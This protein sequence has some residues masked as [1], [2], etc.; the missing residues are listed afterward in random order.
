MFNIKYVSS[1]QVGRLVEGN[2]YVFQVSAENSVGVG[3]PAELSQSITT[4]SPFGK[5]LVYKKRI[6]SI[7]QVQPYVKEQACITERERML[8]Y[9][10][11]AVIELETCIVLH[12]LH[13]PFSVYRVYRKG[14]NKL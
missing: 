2:Q 10:V 13:L 12:F 14:K 5:Y 4:K 7:L 6:W 11:I 1:L 8:N 3:E 9:K